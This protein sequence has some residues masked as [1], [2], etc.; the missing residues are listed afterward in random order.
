DSKIFDYHINGSFAGSVEVAA[1]TPVISDTTHLAGDGGNDFQL[2]AG[3]LFH[4]C[5]DYFER[6]ECVYP[7]SFHPI[8]IADAAKFPVLCMRINTGIVNQNIDGQILQ[9]L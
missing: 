1:T 3:N 7:E 6:G 8:I 2:A 9:L 4:Q 5:F